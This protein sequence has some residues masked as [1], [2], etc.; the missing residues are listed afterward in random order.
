ML[1]D[2]SVENELALTKLVK[3]ICDQE[4]FYSI[5]VDISKIKDVQNIQEFKKYFESINVKIEES[6]LINDLYNTIEESN[7][8][9]DAI[10][11]LAKINCNEAIKTL[12]IMYADG[13]GIEKNLKEAVRLFTLAAEQGD[14]DS[15]FNLALM[16]KDGE[17]VEKNLEEAV[18]LYTLAADQGD[19]D[20]Q[21]NLA[22]MYYNG[23]GVEQNLEEAVRLFTLAAEQGDPSAQFNL[24]LMYHYGE[25]GCQDYTEA[26][27]WYELASEQ[28]HNDASLNLGWMYEN[29][30]GVEQNY[31]EAKEY[32]LLA[33][34]QGNTLA[35]YNLGILYEERKIKC[36]NDNDQ[37]KEAEFW[38]NEAFSKGYAPA[39]DKLEELKKEKI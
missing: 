16:Y 19:A 15:Q 24:G 25:G 13:Y 1:I 2:K 37:L 28:F 3:F 22:L 10:I 36:E 39:K 14:V 33:A 4:K 30:Y 31:D 34:M 26:I 21:F 12:A 27:K 7:E 23:E 32:Y 17:G 11:Y 6:E 8:Y 18:R 38:Y 20:A 9:I 29:G 35:N 5:N